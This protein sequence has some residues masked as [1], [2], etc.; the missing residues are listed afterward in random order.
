MSVEKQDF[1]Q[2]LFR[3]AS[4]CPWPLQLRAFDLLSRA[5]REQLA[6]EVPELGH[7]DGY[8]GVSENGGP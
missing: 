6:T 8:M 1:L 3:F 2:D 7:D 5:S 4:A